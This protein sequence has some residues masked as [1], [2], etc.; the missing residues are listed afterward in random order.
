[1]GGRSAVRRR[2]P[3]ANL[4]PGGELAGWSDADIMRALREGK[5]PDGS[6]L[7]PFMPWKATRYMRTTRSRLWCAICGRCRPKRITRVSERV[8][9]RADQHT[10]QATEQLFCYE[11][12]QNMSF[13]NTSP[14]VSNDTGLE[15]LK[16]L[17]AGAVIAPWDAQYDQAR[18]TWNLSI[19]Q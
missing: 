3:A 2:P 14:V 5:R 7:N 11:K 12:D 6:A 10:L 4:T 18:R 8:V 19:D 1:L 16:S 15:H 13:A 9:P 17:I